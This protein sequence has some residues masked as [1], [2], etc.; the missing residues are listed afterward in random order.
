MTTRTRTAVRIAASIAA[1]AG[2]TLVYVEILP[3]NPT[4]VALTYLIV[5]L[6]IASGWGIA[7]STITSVVAMFCFNFFFLPPVGTLT[8]ADPQNWVALLAFLVTAG[9]ASQISGRARKKTVEAVARQGDLERLY[10]LS[11][12]LLLADRAVPVTG[13]IA[14]HIADAFALS[15]VALYDQR[16]GTVSRAGSGELPGIDARL[17]E[18]ARTAASVHEPSGAVIIAIRLGGTPIGSVAMLADGLSDTVLQ[19]IANLAAIG[20]EQARATEATARAE[21]ARESSELRATVLDALAHEFKTPLT[22]M[23]AASSDL[24]TTTAGGSR[25]HELAS[26][27]D[28]DLN[29]FQSLVTDAVHMLRIDAGDFAVHIGRHVLAPLVAASVQTFGPRLEGHTIVQKIPSDLTVDADRDLLAL[30][31]RQLVDNALKYSPPTSAIDI[32]AARNGTVEIAVHNTGP[33]ISGIEQG[34]VF[35]RF[36][37]GI[38]AK[39]TPGTGMGLAIVRQIARVH[40]GSVSVTSSDAGGTTFTIVLPKTGIPT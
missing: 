34:R 3:V 27:I 23:K 22:S 2:V 38:A 21:A 5:I 25:E 26:I 16:T 10:A 24:L 29:R 14:R 17:R 9:V 11:R 31:L 8:I 28:E 4:T 19:S 20:L 6:F 36:Y 12:G 35:D 15:A 30:A 33:A 37:R 13:G 40:N 39:N 7:E 1:I 32:A 18:V